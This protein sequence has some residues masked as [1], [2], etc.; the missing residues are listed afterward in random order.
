LLKT[1]ALCGVV[2]FLFIAF[3]RPQWNKKDQNIEQQGRDLLVLLDI[4]RSMLAQDIKPNRLEFIK[5]KLKTL[6]KKLKFERVG[7]ILFSGSA[8]VQCPLTADYATFLMFLDHVDVESIASG[9]TAIDTALEKAVKLYSAYPRR[10]NKLVLLVT[11]GEDFS[12]NLRNV[13]ERAKQDN[14][15]VMAL[16]A[17]TPQGAPVPKIDPY[18]KQAGHEVD[19]AGKVVLTKLNEQLLKNVC[20]DL[21]GFYTRVTQND[22]D[23]DKIVTQINKFEMEEF[24]SRKLSI[25]E[26]K[27]PLFL[28]IAAILLAL[29]WV[30]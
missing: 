14:I 28:G 15:T 12:L 21:N 11:D 26:E 30:L 2:I 10:K 7:L 20:N 16:G 23:I 19:E 9:T 6:L 18:G 3:L 29:E 24:G 4:S 22:A 27:Y 17:G 13:Q 1:I 25:Y 8:F 5:F